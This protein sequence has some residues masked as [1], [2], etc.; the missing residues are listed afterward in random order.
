MPEAGRETAFPTS[1]K[2]P[3]ALGKTTQSG[4]APNHPSGVR[5]PGLRRVRP[6]GRR[7]LDRNLLDG[8][9]FGGLAPE[10]GRC[11]V[12]SAA[13]P[14]RSRGQARG[15]LCAA[16]FYNCRNTGKLRTAVCRNG[17]KDCGESSAVFPAERRHG[18]RCHPDAGR[19][20]TPASIKSMD[21]PDFFQVDIP[22]PGKQGRSVLP[23]PVFGGI[24]PRQNDRAAISAA[25]LRSG[26][27]RTVQ[28][29]SRCEEWAFGFLS[30]AIRYTGIPS[31]P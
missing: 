15:T 22:F 9:A 24:L 23:E 30:T 8:G 4:D 29:S 13:V 12:R 1:T 14:G 7:L 31:R 26:L 5:Q 19:R 11:A 17:L 16:S 6:F 20:G 28:L 3:A 21:P 27:R 2:K 10:R 18:V 25:N